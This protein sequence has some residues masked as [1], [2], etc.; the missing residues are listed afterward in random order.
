[1]YRLGQIF[2]P[3]GALTYSRRAMATASS[4]MPAAWWNRIGVWL[5]MREAQAV[6]ALSQSGS[7]ISPMGGSG[8]SGGGI[9]AGGA[10]MP[11]ALSLRVT[12]RGG[13]GFIS[14]PCC[15]GSMSSA[16]QT[17]F[18]RIVPQR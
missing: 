10:G 15:C 8:F 7:A 6:Y 18:A 12:T 17:S 5:P 3:H 16:A 9:S 11:P 4:Q 14:P 2:T 13:V 1:M